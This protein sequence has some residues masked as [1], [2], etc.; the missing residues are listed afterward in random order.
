MMSPSKTFVPSVSAINHISPVQFVVVSFQLLSDRAVLSKP[1]HQAEVAGVFDQKITSTFRTYNFLHKIRISFPY[2][3][4]KML[5]CI[6]RQ[7]PI[8]EPPA[9]CAFTINDLF[10]GIVTMGIDI[11][12]ARALFSK[13]IPTPNRIGIIFVVLNKISIVSH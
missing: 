11:C 3:F 12:A 1:M 2:T 13:C 9:S 10:F 5:F 6:L 4:Y 8:D 7:N